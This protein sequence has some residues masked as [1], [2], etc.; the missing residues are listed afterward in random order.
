MIQGDSYLTIIKPG[1]G[2]YKEKGSRFLAF[3]LPAD[4][5]EIVKSHLEELRKNYYDARHHCYAYVLG[6][7]GS[8]FRAND[9]GEPGH[10]AGDPILGQIRSR[11]LTNVLVVVVR[12]FGG[13]KLGVGGLINAYKTAA[14]EALDKAG[15]KEVEI[16]Q[17]VVI[18]FNYDLTNEIMSLIRD[19]TIVNQTFTDT[20]S[21]EVAVNTS[22][23]ETLMSNL[24]V[25]KE[26]KKPVEFELVNSN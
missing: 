23:L 3:A 19:F 13:T 5:E 21:I 18:H 6:S 24:H 4:S 25:L 2:D 10:S 20:C 17:K 11:E 1:E 26:K 22:M 8:R 15:R 9:D 12:Y 7:E 14:S 16:M